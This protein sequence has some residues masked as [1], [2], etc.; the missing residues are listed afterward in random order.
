MENGKPTGP[1]SESELIAAV[2]DGRVSHRQLAKR[3]DSPGWKPLGDWTLPN[4][5]GSADSWWRQLSV[6]V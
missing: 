4:L 6:R 5:K 3:S 2:S 1:Y